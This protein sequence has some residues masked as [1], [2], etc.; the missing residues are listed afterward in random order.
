MLPPPLLRML[1]MLPY[2]L[3]GS[4]PPLLATAAAAA[5]AAAAEDEA[6]PDSGGAP[7]LTTS[8]PKVLPLLMKLVHGSSLPPATESAC[9][10]VGSAWLGATHGE[11]IGKS[12]GKSTAL[13]SMS[14]CSALSSPERS[15]AVAT[16][17][18]SSAVKGDRGAWAAA[19]H[20]LKDAAHGPEAADP[21]WG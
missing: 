9:P 19:A 15:Q 11:G 1:H 2:R 7:L 10:G 8:Q 12:E 16:A 14:E 18:S 3:P 17:S 21:A 5:A 6:G 20:G 13:R 4:S